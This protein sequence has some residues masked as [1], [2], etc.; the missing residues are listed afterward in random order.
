[1]V[2]INWL[3]LVQKVCEA[4]RMRV[5]RGGG[6]TRRGLRVHLHLNL[7][8]L[9]PGHTTGGSGRGA[10]R[11]V[12]RGRVGLGANRIERPGDKGPSS[13]PGNRKNVA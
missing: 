4:S 10:W 11:T 2:S 7:M 3:P 1:M 6:Q 5:Q 13:S 12:G 9:K 8:N